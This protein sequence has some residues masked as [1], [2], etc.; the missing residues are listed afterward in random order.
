MKIQDNKQEAFAVTKESQ[1]KQRTVIGSLAGI[2]ALIT[3]VTIF[4]VVI[5]RQTAARQK[6]EELAAQAT[7]QQVSAGKEQAPYA[8]TMQAVSQPIQLPDQMKAAQVQAGREFLTALENPYINEIAQEQVTEEIRQM[9]QDAADLG[10]D[11]LFVPLSSERGTLWQ[12][13]CPLVDFDVLDTLC[14]SAHEQGIALY[15]VYDLSWLAAQDGTM[16]EVP[17]VNAQTLDQIAA[18]LT[19]LTEMGMLDGILLDGYQNPQTDYSYDQYVSSGQNTSLESYMNQCTEL[20]V[21]SA[22][23]AV[24]AVDSQ[25]PVGLAVDPVWATSEEAE[26]GLEL[27]YTQTSLGTYH[28]DTRRMIEDRLCDFVVVKN[29]SSMGDESLPFETV[30]SWWNQLLQGQEITAYMGHASSKAAT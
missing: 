28:A 1:N 2:M 9:M 18:Q 16:T 23:D 4:T 27:A 14:Q 5:L 26:G 11:T 15:G 7:Q 8:E 20:L 30:A 13:S 10:L 12:S 17:V 24:K 21:E 25:M 19:E 6:N 22:V 29:E 3:L